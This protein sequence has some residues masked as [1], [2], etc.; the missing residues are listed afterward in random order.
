ST[1]ERERQAILQQSP[2]GMPDQAAPQRLK[3]ADEALSLLE[4]ASLS[5]MHRHLLLL[6]DGQRTI[7]ELSRLMNRGEGEILR[8]LRDLAQLGITE[9]L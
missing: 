7:A 8:L 5:R 2:A 9:R 4:S 6:L 3:A 1:A